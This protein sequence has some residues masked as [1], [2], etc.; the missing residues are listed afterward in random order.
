MG[1]VFSFFSL[2]FLCFCD[3]GTYVEVF[4]TYSSDVHDKRFG[5]VGWTIYYTL[6]RQRTLVTC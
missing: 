6:G 3:F 2:T 4:N 5:K 1:A